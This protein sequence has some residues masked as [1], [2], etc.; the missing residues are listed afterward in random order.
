[1]VEPSRPEIIRRDILDRIR[2]PS[3]AVRI[4]ERIIGGRI[5]GCNEGRYVRVNLSLA[6]V[7]RNC[8]AALSKPQRLSQA[9]VITEDEGC[10]LM[11]GPAQ[12]SAELIAPEGG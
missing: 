7:R 10:V 9:L 11:D 2:K 4:L 12:R 3:K 8:G 5:D 6:R 1:M